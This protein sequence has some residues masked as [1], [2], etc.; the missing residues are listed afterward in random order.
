[1]RSPV[2]HRAGQALAFI[3][4]TAI[5]CVVTMHRGSNASWAARKTFVLKSCRQI[6]NTAILPACHYCTKHSTTV[7]VIVGS[8]RYAACHMDWQ[9]AALICIT[10]APVQKMSRSVV[11]VLRVN[12]ESTCPQCG[13]RRQGKKD[14]PLHSC[15]TREVA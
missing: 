13:K 1:M 8:C 2:S 5:A 7:T 11:P 14:Q 4:Y 3:I 12:V 6:S 9:Q 10:L 15:T